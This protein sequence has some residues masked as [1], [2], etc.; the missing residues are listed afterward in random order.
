MSTQDEFIYF[1]E[2]LLSTNSA[3]V[4]KFR[5]RMFSGRFK[6]IALFADRWSPPG[7]PS[8]NDHDAKILQKLSDG[9]AHVSGRP[10]N[11]SRLPK[12]Y[13]VNSLIEIYGVNN[14]IVQINARPARI[15]NHFVN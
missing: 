1:G 8:I 7:L 5:L 15:V 2:F 12:L 13:D 11:V 4:H 9:R 3:T 14:F 10:Q 6:L